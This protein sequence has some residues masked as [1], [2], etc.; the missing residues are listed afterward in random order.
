MSNHQNNLKDMLGNLCIT[1]ITSLESA[2]G[3]FCEHWLDF[4][5]DVGLGNT[6]NFC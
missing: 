1:R 3:S 5:V 4:L 2:E 6:K